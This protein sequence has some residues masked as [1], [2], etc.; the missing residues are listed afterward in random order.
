MKQLLLT[1]CVLII[2]TSCKKENRDPEPYVVVGMQLDS[3]DQTGANWYDVTF[4]N[5]ALKNSY[6]TCRVGDFN[7]GDTVL[8]GR[9]EEGEYIVSGSNPEKLKKFIN[10]L[11]ET[12]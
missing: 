3:T 2:I 11:K 7:L 1:C 6:S 10:P 12:K 9:N 8:I 4:R 5:S